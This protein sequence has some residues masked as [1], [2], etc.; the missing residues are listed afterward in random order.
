MKRQNEM[1]EVIG[2]LQY[3]SPLITK[4]SVDRDIITASHSDSN[5][6]EWDTDLD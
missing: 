3:S 5:M 1:K 4:M 6:G 2:K